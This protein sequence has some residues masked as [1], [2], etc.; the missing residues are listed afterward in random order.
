MHVDLDVLDPDEGR[1]N[2]YAAAEGLRV[3]EN[4]WVMREAAQRLRIRAITLSACDPEADGKGR[5]PA[6]AFA[7]LDAVLRAES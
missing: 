6:A 3:A 5:I 2:T 4:A 7:L 1:A